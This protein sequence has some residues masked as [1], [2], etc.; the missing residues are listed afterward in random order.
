PR[1]MPPASDDG[2]A[3]QR[4]IATCLVATALSVAAIVFDPIPLLRGPAPYP[5]EWQWLRREA[6]AEGPLAPALATVAVLLLLLRASDSEW[7]R[8]YAHAA[9]G[10][11]VAAA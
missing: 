9:A 1:T 5:P 3:R 8:K 4:R 10:F 11:V 6:P 2:G 7:A